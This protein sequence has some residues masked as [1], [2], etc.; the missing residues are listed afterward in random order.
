MV[1][2]YG[3]C[4]ETGWALH[5]LRR[6]PVSSRPFL[7]Q[8]QSC[9]WGVMPRIFLCMMRTATS[10][11][12]RT[13][14]LVRLQI[15]HSHDWSSSG[16]SVQSA[17]TQEATLQ[18]NPRSTCILHVRRAQTRRSGS[19]WHSYRAVDT[20]QPQMHLAHCYS[21]C[22]MHGMSMQALGPPTTPPIHQSGPWKMPSKLPF[23]HLFETTLF[24]WSHRFHQIERNSTPPTRCSDGS[25][26]RPHETRCAA[27]DQTRTS[28]T[29]IEAAIYL[30]IIPH[31]SSS[32]PEKHRTC[33]ARL[34]IAVQ[35]QQLLVE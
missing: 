16:E 34:C 7:L 22:G 10:L 17:F 6:Q 26:K 30:P 32:S 4:A 5:L 24:A 18:Q 1:L 29:S 2:I 9:Y 8:V 33:S 20:R 15:V 27:R 35:K 11:I 14:P 31:Q 12:V 21:A 3:C 28:S 25:S 19:Q 13:P 23:A